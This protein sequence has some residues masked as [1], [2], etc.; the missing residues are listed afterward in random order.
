M[1]LENNVRSTFERYLKMPKGLEEKFSNQ[2]TTNDFVQC[3][4]PLPMFSRRDKVFN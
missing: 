3:D 1:N 2:V 4:L